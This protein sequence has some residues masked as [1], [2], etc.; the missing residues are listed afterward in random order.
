[1][2]GEYGGANLASPDASEGT[3]FSRGIVFLAWGAHAAKRVVELDQ[4]IFL[5]FLF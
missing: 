5:S 2:V 1:M 4:V 3:G